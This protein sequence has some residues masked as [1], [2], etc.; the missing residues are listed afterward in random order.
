MAVIKS[1]RTIGMS[2]LAAG[3]GLLAASAVARAQDSAFVTATGNVG[4]GTANPGARL[5][6]SG[7]EVRLPPGRDHRGCT[8]PLPPRAGEGRADRRVAE[9]V[10]RIK[11]LLLEKGN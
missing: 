8:G 1:I 10:A 11:Q 3:L 9:G 4:I 2:A 5:E 7:G 6:V